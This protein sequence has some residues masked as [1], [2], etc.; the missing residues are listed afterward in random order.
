MLKVGCNVNNLFR[1]KTT[2]KENEN[3]GF[4]NVWVYG[5]LLTNK[6]VY[7]IHPQNNVFRVHNELAKILIAHEVLKETV[8]KFSGFTDK[9]G[10]KVFQ[11]DI[12]KNANGDLFMVVQEKSRIV[13]RTEQ[14]R[15][16][17]W[18]CVSLKE[19]VGNIYEG[20]DLLERFL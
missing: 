18:R 3:H 1:A 19:V 9:N 7:Y 15:V 16:C 4:N 8:G 11:G 5:D 20:R 14:N 13:L 12:L 10:N 17:T 6:G 2:K